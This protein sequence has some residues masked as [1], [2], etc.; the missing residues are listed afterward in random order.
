LLSAGAAACSGANHASPDAQAPSGALE[1][2]LDCS[3]RV[4]EIARFTASCQYVGGD[5]PIMQ[6][7]QSAYESGMLLMTVPRPQ[8]VVVGRRIALG[9]AAPVVKLEGTATFGIELVESTS[10]A[11][12]GFVV[13]DRFEPGHIMSGSFVD[14]SIEMQPDPAFL[15]RLSADHFEAS[16][17]PGVTRP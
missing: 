5:V 11:G 8:D 12:V 3:P 16:S 1:L 15:C 6:C 10:V 2:Q 9:G 14:T 4:S 7:P 13:F 17:G